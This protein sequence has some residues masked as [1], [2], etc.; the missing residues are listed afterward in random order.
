[1]MTHISGQNQP[2]YPFSEDFVLISAKS[3]HKIILFFWKDPKKLRGMKMLLDRDIIGV[4]GPL[5]NCINMI[6]ISKSIMP[7]VVADGCC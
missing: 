7:Q 5:S 2:N 4:N 1:M 6:R 3:L